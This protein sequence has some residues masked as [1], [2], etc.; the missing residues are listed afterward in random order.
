MFD[1]SLRSELVGD[2]KAVE[3]QFR[4]RC[5]GN[6]D[7]A[8]DITA[9]QRFLFIITDR[10]AVDLVAED[11]AG[12]ADRQNTDRLPGSRQFKPKGLAMAD[13]L[14]LPNR[15]VVGRGCDIHDPVPFVA[16]VKARRQAEMVI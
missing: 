12:Q 10:A 11:I 6:I 4:S 14:L 8:F 9:N 1:L 2:V 3:L 5:D 7:I 15:F 13:I 16:V